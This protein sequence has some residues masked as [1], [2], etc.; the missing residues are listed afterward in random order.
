MQV[1][2]EKLNALMGKMV[3]EFGAIASA[4]LVVLGDRLGLY[5]AMAGAGPM[6]A[7]QLSEKTRLRLRYAQEWL[8]AQAA[9]GFVEY[10]PREQTYALSPEAAMVLADDASPTFMGGGYEVMMSMYLDLDKLQKAFVDG[11]GLGWHEHSACL[12]AGT[13]RF[14]RA[15]YNAH[16]EPS[17][18]PALD[19]MAER[20]RAGARVADVGCGFGASTIVLARAYPK[21]S[22]VGYDYHEPSIATARER[23]RE[24]GVGDRVSFEVAGAKTYPGRGFDLVAFFDCL[25]DMG[26]PVGAARH[27]RETL[28]DDGIWMIVEPFAND[29]VE[30]N[31]NP[32]GRIYYSAST[33]VCT[34]CSLSQEVGLGLGAQAGE[35]RLRQVAREGGFS[36]FRRAAETPFNLVFEA[37]A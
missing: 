7:D 19:G 9:S 22:F 36:R 30:D 13:E 26:D 27:V 24:A 4:P 21:S 16:L 28:A 15:G 3:G 17:W 11:T 23:A 20:L 10:E 8:N 29:R 31:L 6:T 33:M 5:K 32:V 37:R 2:E 12:F 18:I 34:P 35:E 25:H 14:F 1:D